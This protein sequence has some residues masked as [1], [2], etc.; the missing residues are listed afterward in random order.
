MSRSVIA[1][2]RDIVPLRP[3]TRH[4]ALVIAERQA[5]M[6]RKLLDVTGPIL[7]EF[8]LADLPRIEVLRK[9]PWPVSGATQWVNGRWIIVLNGAEPAVRQ[10]FSLAHELKHI[11]DH[12]F[13]DLLYRGIDETARHDWIEQVYVA[14][15]IPLDLLKAEQDRIT[16]ELEDARR[17]TE[18]TEQTTATILDNLDV[19]LGLLEDPQDAYRQSGPISRRMWNQALFDRIEVDAEAPPQ[20]RLAGVFA[21]LHAEGP[22]TGEGLELK[23]HGRVSPDR[24]SKEHCLVGPAGFEPATNRL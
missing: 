24:G 5:L 3:L 13:V 21:H 6:L 4:E 15:A 12:P 19:V 8:H 22:W 16:R 17:L 11:I 2:L 20:A 7:H 1:Q 10:R 23:N 18:A 14:D 9:S